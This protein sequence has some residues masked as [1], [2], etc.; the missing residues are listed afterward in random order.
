MYTQECKD[1]VAQRQPSQA[2]PPP[3][4]MSLLTAAR[5]AACLTAE[6]PKE[7]EATRRADYHFRDREERKSASEAQVV[8]WACAQLCTA[9]N[10]AHD[11]GL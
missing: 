2:P 6:P 7:D 11:D 8:L 9:R 4:E 1:F 10:C 5:I 3:L